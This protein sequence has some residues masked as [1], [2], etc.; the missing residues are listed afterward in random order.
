MAIFL[1]N[2]LFTIPAPHTAAKQ[3][4]TTTELTRQAF[5]SGLFS[6]GALRAVWGSASIKSSDDAVVEAELEADPSA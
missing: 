5:C 2:V 4:R 3:K 1:E 6:T